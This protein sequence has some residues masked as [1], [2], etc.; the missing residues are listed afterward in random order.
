MDPTVEASPLDRSAQ[1][2]ERVYNAG[3]MH[4][5]EIAFIGSAT[6]ALAGIVAIGFSALFLRIDRGFPPQLLSR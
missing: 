4:Q 3:R 5:R 6:A 2:A 1:P